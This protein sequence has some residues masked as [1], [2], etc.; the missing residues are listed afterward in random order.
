MTTNFNIFL[1]LRTHTP[2]DSV[3][4]QITHFPFILSDLEK[5]IPRI[6]HFPD[7]YVISEK[8]NRGGPLS[9]AGFIL[10]FYIMH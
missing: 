7:T 2:D 4:M 10:L 6:W 3:K 8:T 9:T 1:V 5:A